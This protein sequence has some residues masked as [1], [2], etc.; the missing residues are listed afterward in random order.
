MN[1]QMDERT[2]PCPDCNGE[3]GFA[4][5]TGSYCRETGV[6]DLEW[7]ECALCDGTG[8]VSHEVWLDFTF[9]QGAGFHPQSA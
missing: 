2:K 7:E 3:R 4:F 1:T 9:G 6:P 8:G 5:E